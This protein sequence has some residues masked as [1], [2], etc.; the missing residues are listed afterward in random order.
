MK[1]NRK[2]LLGSLLLAGL[3]FAMSSCIS[4]GYVGTGVYYGEER[5]PWFRDGPWMDGDRW[6]GEPRG[7]ASVGI[8]LHP[9]RGRR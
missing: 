8:Y 4:D 6:Y 5:G 9:P 1:L 7:G 2:M 3:P